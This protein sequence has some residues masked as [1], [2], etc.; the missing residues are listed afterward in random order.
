MR[1]LLEVQ[2]LLT[3]SIIDL[4]RCL[5]NRLRG[6]RISIS[7]LWSDLEAS[8][9]QR[10]RLSLPNCRHVGSIRVLLYCRK[11]APAEALEPPLWSF[12]GI[13]FSLPPLVWRTLLRKN[14]KNDSLDY[15]LG[16]MGFNGTPYVQFFFSSFLHPHSLRFALELALSG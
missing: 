5:L 9:R 1:S 10:G 3:C 11:R 15:S 12:F 13:P 6:S 4:I 16:Q 2:T 14:M 7:Y 8:F